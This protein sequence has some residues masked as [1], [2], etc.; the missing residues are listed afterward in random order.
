MSKA[1]PTLPSPCVD[2]CIFDEATGWCLGCGRTRAEC[3]RWRTAPRR[4]LQ[5]LSAQLPR[6]LRALQSTRVST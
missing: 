3:R 1:R 4:D 5:A 6:R 2:V